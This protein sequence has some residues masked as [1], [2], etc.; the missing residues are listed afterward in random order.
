[1]IAAHLK[2]GCSAKGK[3]AELHEHKHT[4]THTTHAIHQKRDPYIHKTYLKV[5]V[6]ISK[7]H[8]IVGIKIAL[9]KNTAVIIQV[10]TQQLD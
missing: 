8:I 7:C 1:M 4:Y 2:S 9:S 10:F 3:G 5:F 6:S